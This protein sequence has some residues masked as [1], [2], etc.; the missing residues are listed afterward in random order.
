MRLAAVAVASSDGA[1]HGL[2]GLMKR[3]YDGPG[4]C[5]TAEPEPPKVTK[6]I[7]LEVGYLIVPELHKGW[8]RG[9]VDSLH[10]VSHVSCQVWRGR[11]G[12][13]RKSRDI[14]KTPQWRVAHQPRYGPIA[15]ALHQPTGQRL[16]VLLGE[17]VEQDVRCVHI[18]IVSERREQWAV[19]SFSRP[20]PQQ[21]QERERNAQRRVED[22]PENLC[23]VGAAPLGVI[24]S[25]PQADGPA[26]TAGPCP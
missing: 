2:E 5:Q 7:E 18:Q 11:V 22:G 16:T 13:A 17:R 19:H 14:R 23:A 24:D 15:G 1:L 12:R 10:T 6:P 21:Q 8:M 26:P 4:L 20:I 9:R 3:R 25:A